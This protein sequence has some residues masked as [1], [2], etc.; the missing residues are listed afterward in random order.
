MA[1]C[2]G[3]LWI[4]QGMANWWEDGRLF[5]PG[6]GIWLWVPLVAV[7][8]AIVWICS[9]SSDSGNSFSELLSNDAGWS[10]V[11]WIGLYLVFMA[12]DF[13][14]DFSFLGSIAFGVDVCVLLIGISICSAIAYV[15]L[16]LMRLSSTT[17]ILIMALWLFGYLASWTIGISSHGLSLTVFSMIW[18]SLALIGYLLCDM[19]TVPVGENAI[20]Y[21]WSDE[22][23]KFKSRASDLNSDLPK[24]R[25]QT[26]SARSQ[27]GNIPQDTMIVLGHLVRKVT[28]PIAA[29][30]PVNAPM[31]VRDITVK[32]VLDR[33]IAD[34]HS[35][36]NLEGLEQQDID[37]LRS[38]V[39]VACLCC[40]NDFTVVGQTIYRVCLSALLDDWLDNWNANGTSGPSA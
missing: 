15:A 26:R 1:F 28:G 24:R 33:V 30:V 22:E 16:G 2:F 13:D 25:S 10:S 8:C 7:I 12:W 39:E 11:F 18:L 32:E 31:S 29:A 4:A 21:S 37:D 19:T 6:D 27:Y 17:R 14:V 35:N 23:R 38:F 9:K 3:T 5:D 20:D 36:E 34:W 40:G